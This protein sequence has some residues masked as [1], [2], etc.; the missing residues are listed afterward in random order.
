MLDPPLIIGVN[1]KTTSVVNASTTA[2]L[3]DDTRLLLFYIFSSLNGI[4]L[5]SHFALLGYIIWNRLYRNFISSHF[6]AHRTVTSIV[7]CS[8]LL[9]IFI[10]NFSQDGNIFDQFS[11]LHQHSM[12]DRF[13]AFSLCTAWIVT[14][15]MTA[16]IAG[17]HLLTFARI[18]YD[19]LFGISPSVICLFSWIVGASI[20]LPCLTNHSIVSYHVHF[21]QSIWNSSNTGVH[22]LVYITLLGYILPLGLTIFAYGKVLI[23]FYECPLVF[24]ALG[25]FRARYLMLILMMIPLTQAPFY[26]FSLLSET[27]VSQYQLAFPIVAFLSHFASLS[28]SF[29]YGISIWMMKEDDMALVARAQKQSKCP[30][31]L[32]HLETLVE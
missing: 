23:I 2:S 6:I 28:N 12:M 26:I 10:Q 29:F 13:Y 1:N 17:V 24:Q 21:Y 5:L 27:E 19:Q 31:G 22:L 18:H 9:P 16:S 25:V 11:H 20:S 3:S 7:V 4:A 15:F 8:Y 14:H 32:H 30:L